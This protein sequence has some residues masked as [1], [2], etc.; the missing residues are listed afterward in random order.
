MTE[1][2]KHYTLKYTPLSP[3]H[4]G[5]GDSYEPT[6][7]VIKE[8]TLY[9]FDTGSSVTAFSDVEKKELLRILSGKPERGMISAVQKFF[10]DRRDAIIPFAVNAIPV[11]EGVANFYDSRVGK[12]ANKEKNGQDVIHKL[13]IERCAYN[14]ITRN[15]VLLGSSIKG[16]I[17]TALLDQINNDKGL[18]NTHESNRNLQQRL[19]GFRAGKFELDPMRL[20]QISDAHWTEDQNLPKVQICMTVNR[21]KHKVLDEQG[22][23]RASQSEGNQ[24]L[25]KL[26][27]CI[28]AFNHRAFTAS[29][30]LQQTQQW[31]SAFAGEKVPKHTFSIQQ[32]ARACNAYYY[33]K[34]LQEM[35]LLEKRGFIHTA[36]QKSIQSL[37]ESIKADLEQGRTMLLRVGRHSGAESVTL[38]GVRRIKILEG[39]DKETGKTH[40]SFDDKTKT[41]WLAAEYKE[42]RTGL[43]PFGW[44]LVEIQAGE[45]TEFPENTALQQICSEQQQKAQ[46]WADEQARQQQQMQKQIENALK[47]REQ[48][49]QQQLAKQQE[50]E[51]KKQEALKKQQAEAE[52]KA[53]LSPIEREIEEFLE[54]IQVQDRD[55]R[56]LREL[57]SGRW[58]GEDVRTVAK[59]VQE[60]MEE[61]GK[62]MPN[63]TGSNKKK[64]KLKDRSLKVQ[65]FLE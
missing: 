53:Q 1:F 38:N 14:P 48:E 28:P 8:Y 22:N 62:W 39:K 2:I 49:R 29:L 60:L 44:L 56:L 35:D 46:K 7:Y 50:A 58:Q 18:A 16:A 51:R 54:P 24:N 4:I 42:Q 32:I 3:V 19:F 59:K 12:V 26:L 31:S 17:R 57:E 47:Q 9:E 6:N 33:P 37:L 20:I 63:F 41:L 64:L 45:T 13:E 21:K 65:S 27:E 10:Y 23:E 55:T 11:F 25:N 30:N 61:K 34:L 52:R 36:W 5:T 15:P 43:L 40:F